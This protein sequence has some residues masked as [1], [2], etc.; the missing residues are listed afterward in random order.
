MQEIINNGQSKE[1]TI[2]TVENATVPG[3]NCA[4]ILHTR[5]TLHRRFGKIPNL[6]GNIAQ[7]CQ[8]NHLGSCEA[9]VQMD[10]FTATPMPTAQT[11]TQW[12]LPRTCRD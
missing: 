10:A 4:A 11:W 12:R 5:A 2:K 1:R 3:Q 7:H 8:T 9:E 6:S